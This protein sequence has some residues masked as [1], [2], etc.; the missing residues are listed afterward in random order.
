V[1]VVADSGPIIHLGLLGL[2]DLLPELFGRV[3]VPRAVYHEVVVQGAGEP[4]SAELESA[5]WADVQDVNED[6]PLHR[7]LRRELD[8]G[9]SAV[10]CLAVQL[11]AALVLMDER[12][13]RGLAKQLGLTVRGT[14]GILA[15]AKRQGRIEALSPL[16][17]QLVARGI[18][19][20][21]GLIH[22]VLTS[23]GESPQD[24][25]SPANGP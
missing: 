12:A 23:V 10:L 21:P 24:P 2:L 8:A 13:G 11:S 16:L 1:I 19:L 3:V 5:R 6:T 17:K 22:E 4:G 18:W 15:Q 20:S 7:V 25:A 14:L 9:E